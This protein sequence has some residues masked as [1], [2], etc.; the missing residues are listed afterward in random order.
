MHEAVGPVVLRGT[1]ATG[2][3]F[4]SSQGTLRL[5]WWCWLTLLGR[6]DPNFLD[7]NST[8]FD[9]LLGH[10]PDISILE[11]ETFQ[12]YVQRLL[13]AAIFTDSY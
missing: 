7:D 6:H 4:Y 13:C 3:S 9:D 12:L 1:N 10:Y 8:L 5:F 2:D 11:M